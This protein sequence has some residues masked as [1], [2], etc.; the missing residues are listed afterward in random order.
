MPKLSQ[1]SPSQFIAKLSPYNHRVES[2]SLVK[3]N[4]LGCS[5]HMRRTNNCSQFWPITTLERLTYWLSYFGK[6]YPMDL[7]RAYPRH[8][9]NLVWITSYEYLMYNQLKEC[10]QLGFAT[11]N[12]NLVANLKHTLAPLL[13]G[14]GQ[15]IFLKTKSSHSSGIGMYPPKF[16]FFRD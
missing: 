16:E 9:Y 4:S 3:K 10:W 15:F 7:I 2:I 13:N 12:D 6:G 14:K 5:I 11:L 8:S 1:Q